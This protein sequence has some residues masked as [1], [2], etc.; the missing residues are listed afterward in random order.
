MRGPSRS[1]R[2][3]STRIVSVATVPVTSPRPAASSPFE[4]VSEL[5][6]FGR[7]FFAQSCAPMSWSQWPI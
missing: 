7:F 3:V 1:I 4:S 6:S 5:R 2:N